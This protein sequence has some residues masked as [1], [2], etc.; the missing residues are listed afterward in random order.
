MNSSWDDDAIE[1]YE[2]ALP[3]Y[4]VLVTAQR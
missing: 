2:Q 1:V 3:G 4:E